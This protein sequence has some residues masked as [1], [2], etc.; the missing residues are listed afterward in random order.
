MSDIDA[1]E[2]VSLPNIAALHTLIASSPRV[3]VCVD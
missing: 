1:V 2:V 3:K